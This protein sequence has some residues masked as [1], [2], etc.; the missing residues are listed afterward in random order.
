VTARPQRFRHAPLLALLAVVL[1]AGGGLFLLV[2]SFLHSTPAP[3]KK[4]VQEIH[5][6]RPPP[7]PPE[8]PPPP[9]QEKEVEVKAPDP[10]PDQTPSNEPPP[11]QLGLDAEGGAGGDAFGLLGN[12]GGRDL[13]AS[14]GSAY[15]YYAGL[16]KNQILEEL[17]QEQEMRA[18]A[19]SADVRIWVRSDGT[20]ERAN[21]AHSTGDRDRDRAIERVLSRLTRLSQPPPADMP[22]PMSFRIVNRA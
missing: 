18:G 14:G 17:Q 9:P 11:Q 15:V 4:V 20:V 6:I 22:Q 21:L 16:V 13:L 19:F 7:P 8:A 3:T 5:V 10:P 1:I 12:K 2:R